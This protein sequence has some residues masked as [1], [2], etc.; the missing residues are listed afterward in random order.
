[1]CLIGVA[2]FKKE[3]KCSLRFDNTPRAPNPTADDL[4]GPNG[5][6]IARFDLN[7]MSKRTIL[8]NPGSTYQIESQDL[9]LYISLLKEENYDWKTSRSSSR[10]SNALALAFSLISCFAVAQD[11]VNKNSY[12][13]GRNI[14]FKSFSNPASLPDAGQ[15]AH[16]ISSDKRVPSQLSTISE[17]YETTTAPS[18]ISDFE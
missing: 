9:C 17:D 4:L 14:H 16:K 11:Q 2:S 8:L 5:L 3:Y 12:Y 6:N 7:N 18:K 15:L 1:M 10:V 13:V